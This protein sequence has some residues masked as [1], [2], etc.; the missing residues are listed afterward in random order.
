[1]S[2]G[3]LVAS[4]ETEPGHA[5]AQTIAERCP[6]DD[7]PL[8]ILQ[9]T[10]AEQVQVLLLDQ[11]RRLRAPAV[12]AQPDYTISYFSETLV[13]G[14]RTARYRRTSVVR[15]FLGWARPRGGARPVVSSALR[16]LP[17]AQLPG[18]A[19]P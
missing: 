6:S 10:D 9:E 15:Q 17:H 5:Q 19:L 1:V 11:D 3:Q 8:H 2:G 4:A 7:Q 14:D 12:P 16:L 13:V 18:E